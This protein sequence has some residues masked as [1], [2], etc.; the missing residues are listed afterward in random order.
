MTPSQLFPP[1][2]PP[3]SPA[4]EE[5]DTAPAAPPAGA[6]RPK[7]PP[8]GLLAGVLTNAEDTTLA[9]ENCSVVYEP[10]MRSCTRIVVESVASAFKG[11]LL[12][13]TSAAHA[14]ST[15]AQAPAA[16]SVGEVQ[17]EESVTLLQGATL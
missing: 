8:S 4:A 1:V 11:D 6:E 2:S 5:E 12:S 14:G 7:T 15:D 13:P 17:D 9:F 3:C 10:V 16:P